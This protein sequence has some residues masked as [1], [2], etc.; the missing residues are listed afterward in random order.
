MPIEMV[1]IIDTSFDE[2]SPTVG[3]VEVNPKP[4]IANTPIAIRMAPNLNNF[5]TSSFTFVP[6]TTCEDF[7]LAKI[8]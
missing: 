1:K 8:Y 2:S 3:K 7:N 4:I 6:F 5:I